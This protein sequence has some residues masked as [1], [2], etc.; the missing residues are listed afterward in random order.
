MGVGAPSTP[1]IGDRGAQEKSVQLGLLVSEH[2]HIGVVALKIERVGEIYP[3]VTRDI[4]VEGQAAQ[5][6]CAEGRERGGLE[7]EQIYQI[8]DGLLDMVGVREFR[9]LLPSDLSTG[10]KRSMPCTT[11]SWA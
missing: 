7:E 10:M 5:R 11:A 6:L 4:L 3:L 2:H 8:I 9:D 1:G